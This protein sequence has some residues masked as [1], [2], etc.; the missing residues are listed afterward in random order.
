MRICGESLEKLMDG[1]VLLDEPRVPQGTGATA[2]MVRRSEV[3]VK[4]DIVKSPQIWCSVRGPSGAAP[5]DMLL[6][7]CRNVVG[8]QREITRFD[9]LP[10]E[11]TSFRGGSLGFKRPRDRLKGSGEDVLVGRVGS[12]R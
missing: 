7:L 5:E 10:A 9:A 11:G 12:C 3:S 6:I 8:G 2:L 1:G 4:A